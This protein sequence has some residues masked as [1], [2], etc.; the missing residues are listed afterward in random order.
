M[1]INREETDFSVIYSQLIMH[2]SEALDIPCFQY[3]TSIR[4]HNSSQSMFHPTQ[5][6]HGISRKSPIWNAMK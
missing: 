6:L 1:H 4:Q 5:P 3:V 2:K